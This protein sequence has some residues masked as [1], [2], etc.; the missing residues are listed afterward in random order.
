MIYILAY[1]L[2]VT[3]TNK[4]REAPVWDVD[5]VNK[6][7][8]MLVSIM[9]RNIFLNHVPASAHRAVVATRGPETIIAPLFPP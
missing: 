8:I 9:C 6:V 3:V 5:G 7:C 4:L 1:L 2:D